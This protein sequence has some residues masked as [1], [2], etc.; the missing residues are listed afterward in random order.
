M[1]KLLLASVLLT[2]PLTAQAQDVRITGEVTS[3]HAGIANYGF[4]V[5]GQKYVIPMLGFGQ[6]VQ[7]LKVELLK[8]NGLPISF[9]ADTSQII[10]FH[11]GNQ[12]FLAHDIDP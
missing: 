8:Q 3:S 6:A 2:L 5:N 10:T 4:V 9:L 7:A 1:R 11:A 12:G